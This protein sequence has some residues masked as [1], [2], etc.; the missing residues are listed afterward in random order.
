M[1]DRADPI[2]DLSGSLAEGRSEH[3]S[4]ERMMGWAFILNW[5]G[6][7]KRKGAKDVRRKE[8]RCIAGEHVVTREMRSVF[9]TPKLC[10]FAASR[11]CVKIQPLRLPVFSIA[12]KK[13]PPG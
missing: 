10:A 5:A 11:L 12:H 4:V 3:A 13:A 6:R 1:L 2:L 8:L 7:K 9:L